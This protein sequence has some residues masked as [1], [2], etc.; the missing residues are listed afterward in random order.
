MENKDAD[1]NKINIIT[2]DGAKI[3]EDAT[4]KDQD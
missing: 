4:N 2:R 1:G 3:G